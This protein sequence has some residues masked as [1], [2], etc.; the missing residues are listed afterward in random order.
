M[1][2]LDD[3]TSGAMIAGTLAAMIL[4]EVTDAAVQTAEYVRH[5]TFL[6]G[7]VHGG[8]NALYHIFSLGG[9]LGDY[10]LN[11]P[12]QEQITTAF[13]AG[14]VVGAVGLNASVGGGMAVMATSDNYVT[15]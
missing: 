9:F 10:S 12:P 4:P 15:R 5:L 13:E 11:S 3:K 6:D 8:V 1:S 7:F 2:F 14:K